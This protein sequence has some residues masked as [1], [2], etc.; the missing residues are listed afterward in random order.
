MPDKY[1]FSCIINITIFVITLVL[2]FRF[3]RE[4]GMWNLARAKRAFRYFTT[5]SNVLCA[6][7][8]VLI[9]IFPNESWAY[10]LKI[11]GTAGVTVT[12]LTVLLF[13]GRVYGYKPILTGSDLFMHLITPLLALISLCVFERRGIGFA[14]SFIGVLPVVLYAPLYLYNVVLAPEE[15]RWE[16]FYKFNTNG[17]WK[18]SYA[19]MLAGSMLICIALYFLLNI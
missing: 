16:D 14:T 9:C 8:A 10:Y 11:I 6:I 12:M 18:I 13:L 17:N 5:Q 19:I 4:N 15:K 1:V 2:V 7:S 3:F